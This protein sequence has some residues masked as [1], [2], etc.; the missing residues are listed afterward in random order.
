VAQIKQT[1]SAKK[2]GLFVGK[3]HAE[4]G[5]PAI[6]TDTG[7]PIEVEGGE[8]IINK[9]ATALHWEE[10]SKINQSAGNGV[11]IPPPDDADKVL[12]KYSQGGKITV[13]EKK[14]VFDKWRKLVNM[15]YTELSR[16]FHSKDGQTSGL[17]ES[18]AKSQGISSGRESAEWILKM[19]KTNWRKW[20][21]DMWKW[22][23]KQ[24]SFISRMSG[25]QGNLTDEKGKKTP[26]YKALL[27]WGN[28]PKKKNAHKFATGGSIQPESCIDFIKNSEAIKNNGYYFEFK[29]LLLSLGAYD[30]EVPQI[31]S[32][33]LITYNSGGQENLEAIDTINSTELANNLAKL[34][35]VDIALARIIVYEQTVKAKPFEI[36]LIDSI[37]NKNIV[38][39][40]RDT[41]VCTNI[42]SDVSF[43]TGG[44]T[45]T[46]E[47]IKGL[48]AMLKFSDDDEKAEILAKINA[49]E[50]PA[51]KDFA[52]GGHIAEKT[53][54]NKVR[55]TKLRFHLGKG[56][57]FMNWQVSH[58]NNKVV[59]YYIPDDVQIEMLN[60]K[61]VN[62]K[63]TAKKIFSGE[64]NKTPISYV[65]CEKIKISNKNIKPVD[66]K[67][68]LTYNPKTAPNWFDTNGKNIDN[69]VF[70]KLITFGR[71][72]YYEAPDG[73]LFAIGGFVDD[74]EEFAG[75][76]SVPEDELIAIHNLNGGNIIDANKIGGLITPSI[77][78]LKP[79][80]KFTQFGAITLICDKNLIDPQLNKYGVKVFSGDVYS[81]TVPRKLY[82]F[83]KKEAENFANKV[84]N[85]AYKLSTDLGSWARIGSN[86]A[87]IVGNYS[88]WFKDLGKY[89]SKDLFRNYYE[90]FKLIFL[91]ENNIPF[92]IP[93]T[94]AKAYLWNNMAFNLSEEQI[95]SAKK[96]YEEY[97]KNEY[98]QT[99][100]LSRKF[101]EIIELSANNSFE[102]YKDVS[103]QLYDTFKNSFFKTLDQYASKESVSTGM[104]DS[105]GKYLYPQDILDEKEFE[106][107]VKRVV[108]KHK[109]EYDQWLKDFMDQWQGSS[110]FLN[111][112][113]KESWTLQNLVDVTT[114]K[115]RGQEKT[116]VYGLNKA[117]SFAHK[118]FDSIADMKKS[119]NLLE[120]TDE[121]NQL[122][123]AQ[124]DQFFELANQVKY[125]YTSQ[126]DRLDDFSKSFADYFKGK[127]LASALRSNGFSP[128]ESNIEDIKEL[129]NEIRKSPVDYFEAKMQRAVKLNEFKYAVVPKPTTPVD[130][131]V[132]D[133]LK[134]NGLKVF[135]YS[136]DEQ[137][138]ELVAEITK[139]KKVRFEDGGKVENQNLSKESLEVID[140]NYNAV[141]GFYDF[142]W[143]KESE[144][145]N[146][147]EWLEKFYN[148]QFTKNLDT[149]ISK[150]KSDIELLTKRK[151]A[152]LK[153]EAFEQLIIP[154]LGNEVLMPKLSV[155]EKLVLM[156]P[157]A[158]IE[159]IEK[160]FKEAK[161][162]IDEDGSINQ[163]K[164]TESNI[165][166]DDYINLPNFERFVKENP[167]YKGVFN[168]WKKLFDED[169]ELSVKNTY[170]FRYPTLEQ[171]EKLYS[172]LLS[173]QNQEE[174]QIQFKDGGKIT[175]GIKDFS[176][177][178]VTNDY[179]P[180]NIIA[181]VN[182]KELLDRHI[183]D[184]PDFAITIQRNQIGN[185]VEKAK[186]YLENYLNNPKLIDDRT[187]ER[188]NYDARFN[189]SVVGIY[190]GILSFTDGRHRVLSAYLLGLK[191]VPISI[192]KNQIQI[193]K[194][195]FSSFILLDEDEKTSNS[196]FEKGGLIAPNG[197][198]SGLYFTE[199]YN[200][201]RTPEFKAWFGD[202]EEAYKTKDYDGVSKIIDEN[203]EPLIC[204]HN[205]NN[206]FYEFDEFQIGS[207]T[208]QGYYGK[209]FYFTPTV[210]QSNYGH[211]ELNCFLNIKNPYFK[212]S[213][214]RNYE[215]NSDDLKNKGYDGVVVYPNWIENMSFE[216]GVDKSEEVVTYYPEQIKLGN[217]TNTTFDKYNPDIRFEN[218]GAVKSTSPDTYENKLL[219]IRVIGSENNY[220][221]RV[222]Q[223]WQFL[224]PDEVEILMNG[225][226]H[227][228]EH[229]ATIEAIKRRDIPNE[230]VATFIAY[231]HIN[232]DPN[233][234]Q[235]L[236]KAIPEKMENGSKIEENK[237][238]KMEEKNQEIVGAV[239]KWNE[240][241]VRW[242]NVKAV[243]PITF[244]LNPYDKN[245][246]AIV[247]NFLDK[248]P[249]RPVMSVMHFADSGV[250][251]T[252]AH[253]LLH[254][255]YKNSDFK[256][257]YATENTLKAYK[258]YKDEVKNIADADVKVKDDKFPNW[259]AVIPK[260]S[261]FVY[262][263]DTM[264]LYQYLQVA[265]NYA[266][267]ASNAVIF[268]FDKNKQIGFNG[269]FMIQCL[270][271]MMKMQNCAKLYLHLTE[272]SRSML[273]S[274]E[275]SITT[276]GNTYCL[277][278]PILVPK[279][280]EVKELKGMQLYGA[281]DIDNNK[282][283]TCYFDFEDNKIHN[284]DGS[285]ADYQESYGDANAMPLALITMMDR[286][287][288]IAKPR[289]PILENICVDG[290][291]IR[292]YNFDSFI[293][294]ANDWGL[295]NGLYQVKNNALVKNTF[296]S[297]D[298][299]PR[300]N[301]RV[302][303]ANPKFTMDSDVF[304]FYLEKASQNAGN[305]DLRPVMKSIFFQYDRMPSLDIV[306][307][308]GITLFRGSLTK[309]AK[310]L[311]DE[312]F[313]FMMG[314]V[315][316]LMN[317]VKNIDSK[318]ISISVEDKRYRIDAGRLHFE[319][320]LED[321]KY[322]NWQSVVPNSFNKE[323][324]FDVKD[325]YVCMNNEAS[326]MFAKETQLKADEIN[327][328]NQ[329]N[330][331]FISNQPNEVKG[332]KQISTEICE[333]KIENKI[334]DESKPFSSS[335]NFILLMPNSSTN[336]NYFNFKMSAL[337][338]VI[339]TIGK[340]KVIVPYS[341]LNR[342]YI[343][344]SDN[345]NYKTSDVY[346]PEKVK[347][348]PAVKTPR[349]SENLAKP[350][351]KG[352]PAKFK[353]GDYVFV[354]YGEEYGKSGF[355]TK[356]MSYEQYPKSFK[357]DDSPMY[358]I[359]GTSKNI[360]ED[361][362]EISV[363]PTATKETPKFTPEVI[364]IIPKHQL[365]VLRG[366]NFSEMETAINILNM[367][368]A[369]VPEIYKQTEIK[370]K[371]VYLHYFY[372]NQD[373]YV[374]E[375]DK[376]TGECYG[377]ADLG[378]GAELGYMSIPEFVNNG[379]VELDFYFEPKTWSKINKGNDSAFE[380]QTKAVKT[381]VKATEK[382]MGTEYTVGTKAHAT[383][384][385]KK[386]HFDDLQ[387]SESG[388]K[389]DTQEIKQAIKGLEAFLK[390]S[391]MSSTN[392]ARKEVEQ[393]IKGLKAL[394]K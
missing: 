145:E 105:L 394:L 278:M 1:S 62:S 332:I 218:G 163:L 220:Y 225:T 98:T 46:A 87:N 381:P 204:V 195:S 315:K 89:S 181:Y 47:A 311:P 228:L 52:S 165:F 240:V 103:Q 101:Y 247:K 164:I 108:S 171:L 120:P 219:Q 99:P 294:I 27:I 284:G 295:E 102:Q 74:E 304:K 319:A 64:I 212:H 290:N 386:K 382:I 45:S 39:A 274:Y 325:L 223:E 144:R 249:L 239:S 347:S 59:N 73:K 303:T 302:S 91:I 179:Y 256:G 337:N 124:K 246:N 110:Y 161:N 69:F 245:L 85:K 138:T 72:V 383:A 19:K 176:K 41:I 51:K 114:G 94:K 182:P 329:N 127:S 10:L 146:Y 140:N 201:V 374:L 339:S 29:N 334:F 392:K 96:V 375:L 379:K 206:E 37:S 222:N 384:V 380:K 42:D 321:G 235:K 260:E 44:S 31:D 348:T 80:M 35:E 190:D 277:S 267:P 266:N 253:K 109:I 359:T 205:T 90:S 6:V 387:K 188:T 75:G 324:I 63:T 158:T 159:S 78:I 363:K 244:N 57:N 175:N 149:A 362:I 3:S 7:Q 296:G 361:N 55:T 342:A 307:T 366:N 166:E 368:V 286:A 297:V 12:D 88:N 187:G 236:D 118:Q 351:L 135:K 131:E 17:T 97:K 194:E 355:I 226:K 119:S 56:E 208:D 259:E 262:E 376:S 335:E 128:T 67:S 202:W 340:E 255:H 365:S 265:I 199:I 346:K 121:V 252:D 292:V 5:I 32:L 338:K 76:G 95:K 157:S 370:D 313:D 71:G 104:V 367:A 344:T 356:V 100:E 316:Q 130:K 139:K 134:E 173:L 326:K 282:Y 13:K 238:P 227:E 198:R 153:L 126:W 183:I 170:A 314:E 143:N 33:V 242:R 26:K 123:D 200:L 276:T 216:N 305:D 154:A 312:K 77:A 271:A 248:D 306:A 234:Y 4:G 11:P 70:E 285:V 308:D 378:Y 156:N 197:Q 299:Y 8:A 243:R 373:W 168:D 229:T 358:E 309:Y 180:Q 162:I 174:S 116:L 38:I 14:L 185:R 352:I 301:N 210:G 48:K 141:F 189:A 322:P 18:E 136:T 390:T 16:Y 288:K 275:K 353:V 132:I 36:S 257:N 84:E 237:E 291:G 336:G 83:D 79:E 196:R 81:P 125:N 209:G 54:N 377:Y 391:N 241:P 122:Q 281:F 169:I 193:F 211:I 287:I 178:K 393:A 279:L 269:K 15:T 21:D 364:K 293:E 137:R 263:V 318:E 49:L 152:K 148:Q 106:I 155:Y 160:G 283:L 272:P 345:L 357:P 388:A 9:K 343:F 328:F 268:K 68:R 333:L 191:F 360:P 300:L 217:A 133:I 330:K 214:H 20:S 192:P 323:L 30:I 24:I 86:V 261:T 371:V 310:N 167:E 215:L 230:I 58:T 40:D 2:G 117:R 115:I 273:I 372:G 213:S 298:D 327:I 107:I 203:G 221:K 349:K 150:I 22:A 111:G 112:N 317:F 82:Y 177:V 186:K 172:E 207:N 147:S 93:K 232:E 65:Q 113:E 258:Y 66:P 61:L 184:E 320:K 250:V 25:V 233:Y 254:I 53:D 369:R 142:D 60:C 50:T 385:A 43:K 389:D 28:D 251:C 289:L 350:K 354:N 129:A 280:D 23:N 331:V 224:T 270:E 151:I 92:K 34:L 341:D 264:K 231:D